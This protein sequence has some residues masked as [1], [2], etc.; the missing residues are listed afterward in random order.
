M[1]KQFVRKGPKRLVDK[2]IINVKKTAIGTSQ[3]ATI[4]RTAG[5]AETLVRLVGNIAIIAGANAGFLRMLI[6]LVRDGQVASA[7]SATDA[8]TL[9]APEQDVLW[10][11]NVATSGSLDQDIGID[12]KGMR[13]LRKGD[14]IQFL[15]IGSAADITDIEGAVTSF[16]KQ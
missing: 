11:R 8:G 4:L 5:E 13:K 15:A 2:A 9:Y 6:A 14:T 16:Y 7:I 1:S 3:V 10:Y 12:V